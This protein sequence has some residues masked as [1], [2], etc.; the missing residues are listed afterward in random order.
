MLLS[1]LEHYS[2]SPDQ[3]VIGSVIWLHGLGASCHDFE[4]LVPFVTTPSVK[5][6]GFCGH[7]RAKAPRFV[8]KAQSEPQN[9]YCTVEVS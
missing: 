9:F 3:P 8:H 1:H 7:A 4:P 6:D 5:T 2:I